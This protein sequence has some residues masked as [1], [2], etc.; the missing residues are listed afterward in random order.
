MPEEETAKDDAKQEQ[1]LAYLEGISQAKLGLRS[2]SRSLTSLRGHADDDD[3]R[4]IDL[5]LDQND[6]DWFRANRAEGAYYSGNVKFR[7]PK[8]EELASMRGLV[9]YLDG[10]IV[11]NEQVRDVIAAT[12]TL[13][14]HFNATQA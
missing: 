10:V 13:V 14:Q 9:T 4:I 1:K 11:G 6:S 3:T 7:A 2:S 5:Q 12:T 8:P